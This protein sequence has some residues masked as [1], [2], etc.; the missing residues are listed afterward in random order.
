MAKYGAITETTRTLKLLSRGTEKSIEKGG[1]EINGREIEKTVS[2]KNISPLGN[3]IS[4]DVEYL[5][6]LGSRDLSW[7]KLWISVE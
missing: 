6:L 2:G 1:V 5:S 3:K 7:N 4:V